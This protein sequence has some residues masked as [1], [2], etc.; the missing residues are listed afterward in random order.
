MNVLVKFTYHMKRGCWL[1]RALLDKYLQMSSARKGGGNWDWRWA[2]RL[3]SWTAAPRDWLG[4]G[5]VRGWTSVA[6]MECSRVVRGHEIPFS[7]HQVGRASKWNSL[8]GSCVMNGIWIWIWIWIWWFW[9]CYTAS[10][11][12]NV[13]MRSSTNSS[14]VN[15][16]PS[17]RNGC[18]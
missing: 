18:R 2:S 11:S 5:I 4:L 1:G 17:A 8:Q 15:C 13:E 14:C 12:P 6:V 7:S 10:C 16:W 9:G 3:W